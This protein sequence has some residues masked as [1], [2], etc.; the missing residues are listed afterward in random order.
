MGFKRRDKS[1]DGRDS[2][3][4]ERLK[5]TADFGPRPGRERPLDDPVPPVGDDDIMLDRDPG[6]LRSGGVAGGLVSGGR[7]FKFAVIGLVA[8]GLILML[9]LLLNS[10]STT[11]QGKGR[12]KGPTLAQTWDKVNGLERRFTRTERRMTTMTGRL[13]MVEQA[14][15]KRQPSAGGAVSSRRLGRRVS[16][17][18]GEVTR[19]RGSVKRLR[20]QVASLETRLARLQKRLASLTA[21]PPAPPARSATRR[22]SSRSSRSSRSFFSY[23]QPQGGKARRVVYR[24]KGGDTLYSV[25]RRHKVTVT[26]IRR[27]NKLEGNTVKK[28]QKLVIYRR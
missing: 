27:W 25:A 4:D 9:V 14:L 23:K 7:Y 19:L 5:T 20:D 8:A 13:D 11:K 26:D 17:V 22:S 21:A 24:V 15:S 18:S 10:S 28:G 12:T 16:Q 3:L 6:R 2:R 1:S